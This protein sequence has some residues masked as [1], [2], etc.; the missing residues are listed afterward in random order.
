MCPF[1]CPLPYS[2]LLLSCMF[3]S[4]KEKVKHLC[5][6]SSYLFPP[7]WKHESLDYSGAPYP[8]SF[9]ASCIFLCSMPPLFRAFFNLCEVLFT[10]SLI[11]KGV[12]SVGCSH[13]LGKMYRHIRILHCLEFKKI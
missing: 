6:F 10:L 11:G 5:N 7:G 12:P 1:R 9:L 8:A 2:P 13:P 3:A 4:D